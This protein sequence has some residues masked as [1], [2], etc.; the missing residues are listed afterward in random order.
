MIS[1]TLKKIVFGS[2][3]FDDSERYLEFQYKFLSIVLWFGTIATAVFVV[4]V[5]AEKNPIPQNHMI[6]MCLFTAFSILFSLIMR[7]RKHLFI[8]VAMAY[9][10]VCL[11]EYTSALYYVPM[12]E[13][14]VI[15]FFTNIPGVYLLLGP[16]AGIFITLVTVIGLAIGNRYLIRPYSDNAVATIVVS[17]SY[18]SIFF[19]MF[20]QTALS[21][22]NALTLSN[23]KLY[24]LAMH[25]QLT[26]VY[27]SLAYYQKSDSFIQEAKKED[28]SYAVLFVDL[29]HFKSIN[30]QY[31]H[32][33]G[34]IV[35]KS[36]ASCMTNNLG[37]DGIL[38]RIGG[39]EFCILLKNTDKYESTI[40]AERIRS[41]I[42]NL[43]PTI[44]TDMKIRI[45]ASIGVAHSKDLPNSSSVKEIQKKADEA[46]YYA[47]KT[48]RNRVS[49]LENVDS[50]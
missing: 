4:G 40:V 19:Y 45:T 11:L 47:K 23:K 24:F 30:D 7:G 17:I 10:F 29:D 12:D 32:E 20:V 41:A 27:N 31:G 3:E 6:S 8:Y 39:E 16:R 1:L 5:L 15:W 21:F 37:K 50:K 43:M 33:A 48:G 35:L 44:N 34:D 9:E 26:G 14:R 46:M 13:F 36:V 18:L 2:A 25:D 22:A 42:E 28:L 49:C 38:G